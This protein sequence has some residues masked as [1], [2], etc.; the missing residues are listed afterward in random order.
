MSSSK[1]A[2]AS[3]LAAPAGLGFPA[4]AT[5]VNRNSSSKLRSAKTL[6]VRPPAPL[7]S[8]LQA[9]TPF[10]AVLIADQS[11]VRVRLCG[12]FAPD[13]RRRST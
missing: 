5:D 9:P 11:K 13:F 10:D 8:P 6:G 7:Y 3:A 4:G 12:D 1:A 2:S